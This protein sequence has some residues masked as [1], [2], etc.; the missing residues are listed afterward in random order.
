MPPSTAAALFA[1]VALLPAASAAAIAATTTAAQNTASRADDDL[2]RVIH[3]GSCKRSCRRKGLLQKT[4]VVLK[5]RTSSFPCSLRPSYEAPSE[6]DPQTVPPP[7]LKCATASTN[8]RH[9]CEVDSA[10]KLRSQSPPFPWHAF[11]FCFRA[12][13]TAPCRCREVS[14]RRSRRHRPA[15][16]PRYLS[17]VRGFVGFHGDRSFAAAGVFVKVVAAE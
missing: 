11:L 6:C 8:V 17:R 12:S 13:P 1:A 4:A 9:V 3:S 5:G 15:G 14:P 10:A 7:T 16:L 2:P